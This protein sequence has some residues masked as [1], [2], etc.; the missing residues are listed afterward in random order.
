MNVVIKKNI[1]HP[2][3]FINFEKN[4]ILR[5]KPTKRVVLFTN[6]RDEKHMKEWAT[7]HLLLGFSLIYIFDHK[8][9]IPLQKEFYNF[10]K[11]IMVERCE[12]NI[13]PKTPL[14]KKAAQISASLKADWF[15][16]L[17]SDEFLYFENYKDV[18]QM[19]DNYYFAD[20]LAVNW[21]YFGSN[22]HKKEPEGLIMENY[23]KSCSKIDKHVKTFVRPS[24]VITVTNPH[25]YHI[26]NPSRMF[27]INKQRVNINMPSFHEWN[28]EHSKCPVYIAHYVNQSEETYINRKIK[29]PR[30]DFTAFRKFNN[31]IHAQYN[32]IE[33]KSMIKYIQN[34]K[35][36]KTNVSSSFV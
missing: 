7:H 30:D 20:S 18:N 24:Q 21:L 27:S 10:D 22:N 11:R 26:V 19:L 35:Q 17:D 8:S 5:K 33:N 13:A 36:Y 25:Y 3:F 4:P 31:N 6:A 15:I 14:M 2:N 12:L 34:L 1:L 28:I 29:L 16:Y 9:K 23:T 32:D